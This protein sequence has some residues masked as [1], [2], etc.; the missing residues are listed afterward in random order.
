[1]SRFNLSNMTVQELVGQFATIGVNQDEAILKDN[2]ATFTRLFRQMVAIENELKARDGDQRRALLS[3]FTHDNMQVR[4]NAA[5]ATLAVA[6]EA[7]RKKLQVIAD[8]GWPIQGGDAGMCLWNLDRG[9][10]KPT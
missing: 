1:M 4:L 2:N 5:K 10:F 6:P 9:V 3:L 7:A 8:S